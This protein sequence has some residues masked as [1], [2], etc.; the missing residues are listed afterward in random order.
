MSELDQLLRDSGAVLVREKKHRVYRLPSGR[1]LVL[2]KT[3]SD[4]RTEANQIRDLRRL[5]AEA[6]SLELET[7]HANNAK[8]SVAK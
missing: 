3:P 4:R 2:S 1:N 6:K 7:C 5:I 8:K